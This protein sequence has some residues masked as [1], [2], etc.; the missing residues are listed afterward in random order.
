M[1][2]TSIVLELG[3]EGNLPHEAK[4]CLSCNKFCSQSR[5]CYNST[6]F[7]CSGTHNCDISCCMKCIIIAMEGAYKFHKNQKKIEPIYHSCPPRT[8]VVHAS[9]VTAKRVFMSDIIMGF[10]IRNGSL[11]INEMISFPCVQ[12]LFVKKTHVINFDCGSMA[13]VI[14][15][16][17]QS[18]LHIMHLN[19]LI[20]QQLTSLSLQPQ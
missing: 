6:L 4:I 19:Y 16:V 2:S 10:Q 5:C 11:S 14:C 15:E 20:A 12:Y 8:D 9:T 18:S 17:I 7:N 1:A 13:L 3:Q